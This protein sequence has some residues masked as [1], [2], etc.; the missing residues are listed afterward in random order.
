MRIC[1]LSDSHD[2]GPMMAA[3]VTAAMAEGADSLFPKSVLDSLP[4]AERPYQ[5]LG[6]AYATAGR[7]DRVR[8]LQA[9]WAR[10]RPLE[11]RTPADSVYWAALTAQ[12]DGRWRDAALAYDDYRSRLKCPGCT[13]TDAARAWERAGPRKPQARSYKKTHRRG[14]FCKT[15]VWGGVVGP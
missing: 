4:V 15:G 10:M 6:Y 7:V 1:I 2:R 9:E 5:G 13:L 8:Q 11:E 14:F 3:A 12:A